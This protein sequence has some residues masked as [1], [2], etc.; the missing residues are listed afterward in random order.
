MKIIGFLM[1]PAGWFLALAA[2]ALLRSFTSQ[3]LFVFAALGVEI[4]GFV[5][6]TR[7]HMV[8]KRGRQ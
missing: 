1:L 6:F 2:L 7:A 8:P 4:M 5:L 3:N